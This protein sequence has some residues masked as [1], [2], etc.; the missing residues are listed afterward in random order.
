MQDVSHM[1]AV[2]LQAE[3]STV[4]QTTRAQSTRAQSPAASQVTLERRRVTGKQLRFNWDEKESTPATPATEPTVEVAPK[5]TAKSSRKPTV[6]T[7]PLAVAAA[8]KSRLGEATKLGV[9]MLRLLKSYGISDEEI[10]EGLSLPSV[11]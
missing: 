8:N 11:S 6:P 10:I 9:V 5:P 7:Q 4:S 3:N 2:E 1:V